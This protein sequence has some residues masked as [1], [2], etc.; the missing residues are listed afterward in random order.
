MSPARAG[1]EQFALP[2]PGVRTYV[3]RCKAATSFH[4]AL[5]AAPG[6]GGRGAAGGKGAHPAPTVTSRMF[7]QVSAGA[8]SLRLAMTLMEP[9]V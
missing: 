2:P 1:Q 4:H 9:E 3:L 5:G 8:D 6:V 7:A